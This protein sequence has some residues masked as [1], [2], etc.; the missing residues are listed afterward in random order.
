MAKLSDSYSVSP[1]DWRKTI[2][3]NQRRTRIVIGLFFLMYCGLGILVDMYM[4]SAHYPRAP[5]SELFVALI[6][7]RI[8]PIATLIMFVV[9]AVSLWISYAMYDKL[10]LLG[11]EYHE[12]TS[13]NARTI[14]EKQLYH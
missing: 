8:F 11:T 7:F 2:R 5:L 9:A 1:G 6:T 14:E 13:T 3:Q 4:V 10:M 12:V